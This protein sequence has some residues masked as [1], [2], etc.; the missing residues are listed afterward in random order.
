M[1]ALKS[2][3]IHKKYWN[4]QRKYDLCENCV[5]SFFCATECVQRF[6]VQTE[7][8]VPRSCVPASRTRS[9][10]RAQAEGR[11]RQASPRHK[12]APSQSAPWRTA[13]PRRPQTQ[14]LLQ[15]FANRAAPPIFV[16]TNVKQSA[17]TFKQWEYPGV[18]VTHI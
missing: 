8:V 12:A 1:D 6:H 15:C 13:S 18:Y 17:L 5:L 9:S 10:P 4:I 3:G 7:K 14:P 11:P 2:G 16:S